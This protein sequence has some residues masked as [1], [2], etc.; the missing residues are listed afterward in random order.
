MLWRNV[1]G[2][3]FV[4]TREAADPRWSTGC[5]FGD[6]DRDGDVDLYVSN[7]VKFDP[8]TTPKR[9]APG[10]KFLNIM[11]A[12]GPRPLA[13]EPDRLY[14]NRGDG[15]FTDVTKQAGVTE[16]GYYGFSACSAISMT[17]GGRIST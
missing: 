12:C 11:V 13:G 3:S 16:P 2:R 8:K 1:K 14:R 15:T 9:G 6:Y 10:C 5:A 4:A 7:Y 17:T